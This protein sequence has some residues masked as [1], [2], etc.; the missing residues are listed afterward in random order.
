MN[1][2]GTPPA[3]IPLGAAAQKAGVSE[4]DL[5][6]GLINAGAPIIKVSA[7]KVGVRAADLDA[8]YPGT[9]SGLTAYTAPNFD[10]RVK[11]DVLWQEDYVPQLEINGEPVTTGQVG[12]AYDGFQVTATGGDQPYVFSLV[13]TWPDGITIDPDTGEVSGEP[14]EDGSFTNLSVRV[15][16]E[17]GNTAQLDAFTLVISEA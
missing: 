4:D 2:Y 17:R 12:V 6:D 5:I 8:L 13:G 15:T 10:L 1:V 7:T 14:E 3:V 16:D 9:S 11:D